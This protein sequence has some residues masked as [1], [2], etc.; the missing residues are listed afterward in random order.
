MNF[1]DYKKRLD[2]HSPF[3]E[4]LHE[5]WIFD[6][7]LFEQYLADCRGLIRLIKRGGPSSQTKELVCQI[8]DIFEYTLLTFFYHLKENDL[9]TIKNYEELVEKD[10]FETLEY[11]IR[12]L[13]KE[14]IMAI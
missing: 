1:S 14:L 11:G 8:I 6:I 9:S 7:D 5:K 4:A 13:S 3:I 10:Y 12:Q 2:E